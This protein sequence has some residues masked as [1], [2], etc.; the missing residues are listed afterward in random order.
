MIWIDFLKQNTCTLILR[1]ETINKLVSGLKN[2]D[3]KKLE[4]LLGKHTVFDTARVLGYEVREYDNSVLAARILLEHTE[5]GCA[6]GVLEYVEIMKE[7]LSDPIKMFM[8]KYH[9]EIDAKISGLTS[10][11]HDWLSSNSLVKNYLA[12]PKFDQDIA[13]T[14]AMFNMRIAIQHYYDES[15]EDVFYC[16]DELWRGTFSVASPTAFNAG[17]KQAQMASCF[18]T[19]T[20]DSMEQ[21]KRCWSIIADVSRY[22]G[23]NGIDIS[24]IRHSEIGHSGMSK[25]IIPFIQVMNSITRLVDQGG[26]RSGATTVYLRCHHID[27]MEFCELPLK[28]GDQYLRAH[29]INIAIWT[30]WLFW[31]RVHHDMDWTLFCPKKT[32]LLN[33]INCEAFIE[34]YLK[35]ELDTSIPKHARRTIKAR[36]LLERIC[37]SQNRASMPYLLNGDSANFKSN[38]KN[39]GNI[40]CSNL[41]TEIIEFSDENEI[42]CCNLSSICLRKFV[43]PKQDRVKHDLDIN[44]A[45]KSPSETSNLYNYKDLGRVTRL[46]TRNLNKIIDV[47]WL[48]RP[49]MTQSNKKH[50]PIGIGVSSMAETFHKLDISF[51]SNEAIEYNKRIFACMYFNSLLESIDLA[52]KDGPYSTFE[53]SPASQGK[54]QFDLWSDEYELM[55]KLEIPCYEGDNTPV[56]PKLFMQEAYTLRNGYIVEPTWDAIK[57]AII[58]FGLRNSLSITVMPTATSSQITRSGECTEPHQ[59]NLYSRKLMKGAY[60]IINRFLIKDLRAIGLWEK[61]VIDL[62]Q[63]DSGSIQKLHLLLKEKPEAFPKFNG[64]Y[65]RLD[66]IKEKYKTMWELS[67]KKLLDLTADRARYVCQ[68][69]STNIYIADPSVETLEMIHSYTAKLRLKTQMYYLR[70]KPAVEAI[71]FTVDADIINF[72][73]S[74]NADIEDKVKPEV[75]KKVLPNGKTMECTDEVCIMCQS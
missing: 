34:Q 14:V 29:D 42:A 75:V 36:A 15:L 74:V 16:F 17:F 40:P 11:K 66:H 9:T 6:K 68:S 32:P 7:R 43:Y 22:N 39:L 4:S 19:Q 65:A 1:M 55:N 52:I 49:E 2:I 58:K 3:L 8:K 26:K 47:N 59:S 44:N 56:D 62:M 38:Q 31:Y 64:D 54:L 61:E 24:K 70:S 51:E 50:R 71:K 18:L 37:S 35:Y 72:V 21:W 5:R 73:E 41:C 60:P 69:Q 33:D 10:Q 57:A 28:I 63:V 46:V 23:G 30:C 27:V 48:P 53:G 12:R 67:Q 25:G 20:G 45:T 13:E